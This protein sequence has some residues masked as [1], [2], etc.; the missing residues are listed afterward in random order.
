MMS[1]EERIKEIFIEQL[2]VDESI[3][4]RDLTL[5]QLAVD[6]LELLELIVAI[7][8]EFD[9]SLDEHQLD[10]METLGEMVNFILEKIRE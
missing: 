3:I 6:S 1:E 8:E 2:K 4:S 10:K 9:I 7:E 5:D